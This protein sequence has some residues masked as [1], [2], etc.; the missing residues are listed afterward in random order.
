MN[1]KQLRA[2]AREVLRGHW[3]AA[4]GVGVMVI[5]L[6]VASMGSNGGVATSAQQVTISDYQSLY[7]GDLL[8]LFDLGSYLSRETMILLETVITVMALASLIL[9]GVISM[10]SATF[11]LHLLKGQPA[12]FTDV[13]SQFPRILSGIAMTVLQ[14]VFIY[15]WSL[16]FI[17]PGIIARFRYAMMPYLMAEFP[18]LSAL[19]AM[20]ESKRLMRG[21]KWRLFCLYFSFIGWAILA[22]LTLGIGLLWLTPYV[23]AAEGAFYMDVTGRSQQAWR[24]ER[25]P[26][27]GPEFD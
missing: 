10:G 13:F 5:L 18:E 22:S 17:I 16:L 27:R 12:K 25:Q 20:R 3:G 15:L 21:N 23:S 11:Q 9:G 2:R 6:G 8:T 1:A 4:I 19:E 7:E 14:M 24:P 26:F